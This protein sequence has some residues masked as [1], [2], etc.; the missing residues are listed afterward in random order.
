MNYSVSDNHIITVERDRTFDVAQTL[1]CGQVFRYRL[2]DGGAEVFSGAHRAEFREKGDSTYIF[3]DDGKYFVKYLDFD[4]NYDIIMRK[5]SDKAL[6]SSAM[7]FAPGIRILA[8]QPLE[9][10]VS[11]IISANNHIPRIQAI[12]ERMCRALGE[13]QADGYFAFPTLEALQSAS[14]ADFAS[15]G[16]GYRAPYLVKT[17][18][19]LS[20]FDFEAMKLEP[21]AEALQQLLTLPGVGPK[22]ADCILLF[23]LGKTDV[24]PVD[25]WIKKVYRESFGEATVPE[26]RR[27]L[28]E[29]YCD[30]SG[31]VQQ[32]LFYYK[33][34][35]NKK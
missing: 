28:L 6:V 7:A 35:T 25:T 5:V 19:A 21:T 26:M 11:F 31:Y 15:F 4:K 20:G 10:V 1:S 14:E 33:R 30:L 16:A 12:I 13:K 22:V 17:A 27:K 29:K 24:F 23:G 9:T 18:K 2:F 3:C 32:Y 8:Q 34:E